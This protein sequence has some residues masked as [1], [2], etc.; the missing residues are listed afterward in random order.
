LQPTAINIDVNT[1]ITTTVYDAQA[2]NLNGGNADEGI[3]YSIKGTNADKFSITTDTGILTYK[4][5]QATA[6]DNDTVTIVATDVAGNEAEQPITVSVKMI[7]LSTSVVWSGIGD[8][9]KLNAS[10]MA[11][12]T[13]SGTVAII[14]TVTSINI[15][16]IVF[17]QGN[18]TVH[19]ISAN[20]PSVNASDNTWTLAN[21]S[22][23]TSKLTQGDYTVTVNLSGNG[24]SVGVTGLSSITTA[25]DTVKPAQPVF[26]FVDTGSLNN[27][28]I[29]NNGL[30]TINNLE[31]NATW[32]YSVNNGNDF[33]NGTG[34]S[35]TLAD[36]T[37]YAANAIQVRQTDAVG[38]VSDIGKNTL[39]IIVDNTDPT[40][41]LQPTAINVNVNTPITTTVYDAQAT[42]LNGGNAD[43]GITY[44]IK[45]ANADK[46][47]ITTD[48]GILTYKT[49]Q[50][51]AHDNDAVTIVATDVAGNEAEQ[52]IT[53]SVE[54]MSLS[55]SVV[56]SGIGSDNKINVDEM[57]ATTL[58]GTV[59]IVGT[60]N[61]ISISSIVFKQGN[62][63][64][65]TI[66]NNLPSIN[67]S[68]NTW[69][70]AN[71]ST[72]TSKLTQ[73]DYTVT[74]NLSGNSGNVTDSS[75]ITT[76]IDTVKPAQPTFDFVDTGS[77]NNDGITNNGLITVNGLEVGATWQYSISGDNGFING[78]NNS[79]TLADNTTYAANAIQVRQTDAVGNVSNIS[80]NTSPIV[81]DTTDPIFERQS[82]AVNANINTPITTTVYDAQA[83]NLSG[84][85]VDEDI[86]YRIKGTN[87]DKFSITTDTGILTYKTIQTSV[88]NDTVTIVATDVAGNETERSI[89]VSV[90]TLVQGFAING[91]NAGDVSGIVSNAGD[92]NGDGLDD[93]IVGAWKA[94]SN[95]EIDSGKSYVIF[96]K[97]DS[98]TINLSA[99]A[100]GTGGF[101]INGEH[102]LDS[103]GDSVSN[104][105]D[106][107]GDG[108]D[109]LIVGAWGA[110][111][112]S[113]EKAGK[114]YVIFGKKDS[115]AIELSAIA[116]GTGGFVINGENAGDESGFPVSTAGDIN[117]DG[118]DDLIVGS[119]EAESRAGKSHVIFGK[120]DGTVIEL[121]AITSGT[122]GFVINGENANDQSST[123]ISNAG[124]VNGDGLDDLII[125]AF[126]ADVSGKSNAGKSYVIFGKKD[127][128]TIDLSAIASGSDT[129]GFVINGEDVDDISGRSVSNAGD[130]NGDGLDDLIVG[131]KLADPDSKSNAGKSYVVFGKT[132]STAINLSAIASGTGGFVINGEDVDDVSGSVSTAGDVNGDGLDDLIVGTPYKIQNG[133]SKVGKFHV[134]FG[135]KD[136]TAI[137]LSA[138]ASGT[139]GF[140]INGENVSSFRGI[141]VSTAGDVNGDGLDDLIVGALG[142]EKGA[143]PGKSYVIFG[144]TDTNAINLTQLNGDLKYAIDHLGDKN[145][146]TLT[147]NSNDEIFVAG[148]GD[149][150]LIGNGGMDVLNAGAGNDTITINASNIA[151]LAQTGAGNR[152]RVDGGGNIDTLELDGSG[153]TLDLTNISNIRIQDIEKIDITGSGNNDL[154]LNLNDVLDAST[155]TNILK[156]LGNSGD[157]VNASGFAKISGVKTEGSI[158]YDVYTHTSANT[159]A[160][161][162]LWIQQ[163]VGV[164]L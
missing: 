152:A 55:T 23:W 25:V 87:A 164:V 45:G 31:M 89:T 70:L 68:G 3:T 20:L 145:A 153:L 111:P 109:D 21:D 154:T 106:V 26:S 133:I 28:G 161:V 74:V 85:T 6:H 62:T 39:R 120:T 40:F 116:S 76:A 160:N 73:G 104:A 140:V 142:P 110:D 7:G 53:V 14:G 81:I 34:S 112:S 94:D 16:S 69:T 103:S 139:G 51:T 102:T 22:T 35:F 46:F 57:A 132:D 148:A 84:G 100:S 150:T 61:S 99:I 17:K 67:A 12:T 78:T 144:K 9:N 135:K 138:I 113:K 32:Q 11:A 98:T 156:V 90:K 1:P 86:T 50:A 130:V 41:D 59:T 147:G 105:G 128:T 121:S 30:I 163:D 108:L 131:A 129:G 44:R 19:T 134:I 117:G 38:N 65:H 118:L 155:S 88:H 162:A 125:G 77:L 119:I 136:N 83:T 36:N 126:G 141:S 149:D 29:T 143:H 54:V 48:T 8:D 37:T 58:S 49:I 122:G 101:V 159:D 137:D 24:N 4:T 72:W 43:E 63:D 146:N 52:P 5:I 27:D 71:D 18:T 158:T 96:G 75:S 56:W 60:V 92:V 47:A 10:E 42:N 93:L 80:K 91:E 2:T 82:T 157:S 13:L 107:N 151:V 127:S 115:T 64:I 79:F 114:S 124:D 33:V 15:S 95:G 123:S 97:I 66:S